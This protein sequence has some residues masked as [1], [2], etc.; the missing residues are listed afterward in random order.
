LSFV[1]QISVLSTIPFSVKQLPFV[2]VLIEISN[3]Y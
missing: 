3:S 2:C 1:K